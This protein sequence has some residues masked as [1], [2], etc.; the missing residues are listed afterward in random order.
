MVR[1]PAKAEEILRCACPQAAAP[2]HLLLDK[3]LF[4]LN[5]IYRKHVQ[6][7]SR[8]LEVLPN[9]FARSV[10]QFKFGMSY[11]GMTIQYCRGRTGWEWSSEEDLP[12]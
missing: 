10:R 7:P 3:T 11:S 9:F 8:N 6:Y 12:Y 4:Y 1:L 5:S 2:A